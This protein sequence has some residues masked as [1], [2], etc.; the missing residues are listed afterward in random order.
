MILYRAQHPASANRPPLCDYSYG[1]R[2]RRDITIQGN[3]VVFPQPVNHGVSSFNDID[4]LRAIL[5]HWP[6]EYK[7]FTFTDADAYFADPHRVVNLIAQGRRS[8]HVLQPR[9]PPGRNTLTKDE[10]DQGLQ[11]IHLQPFEF[12]AS[13]DALA[14]SGHDDDE[15]DLPVYALRKYSAW[16]REEPES[17]NDALFCLLASCYVQRDPTWLEQAELSDHEIQILIAAFAFAISGMEAQIVKVTSAEITDSSQSAS[18]LLNDSIDLTL[19]M[20]YLRER[21]PSGVSAGM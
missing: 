12:K 2:G 14:D 9:L 19:T 3:T 5:V 18:S 21:L 15:C 13:A 10:F 1:V 20:Q 7:I 17:V 8:H 4:T 16:L 6:P 11:Q